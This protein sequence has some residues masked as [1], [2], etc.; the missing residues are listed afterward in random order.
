LK[1]EIATYIQSEEEVGPVLTENPVSTIVQDETVQFADAGVVESKGSG[2]LFEPT[3]SEHTDEVATLGKYLERPVL[4]DQF[5]WNE[6]DT[7]S[8]TPRSIKPWF[9]YF[10]NA[11]IKK[12]LDNFSRVHCNLKLTFR[13]NASPFY[14][15]AMRVVYDP[16]DSGK[17]DPMNVEDIVPMSQ[18]HGVM[19]EPQVTTIA[20]LE[21]PFLWPHSWLN[22]AVA[23]N[24]NRMGKIMFEPFSQLQSA[25]GVT[26]T[27]ITISTYAEA[28]D[29]EISGPTVKTLL[30]SGVVSGPA[31]AIANFARNFSQANVI[32]PY[33]RAVDIGATA[34]SRIAKIFGFSNAPITTNVNP[35]QN[36]VF[37]AFANTETRV[38]IDKLA[39]DPANEVTI[40]NRVTGDTGEDPMIIQKL[41][42]KPS[43]IKSVA[44]PSSTAANTI[45]QHGTVSPCICRT[46]AGT[47]QTLTYYTPSGWVSQCFR[48]WRGGMRYTFRVVRSKYHKGRLIVCWD[49]NGSIT[50]LGVETAIFS[51]IFDL[52][53]EDQEFTVDIPYKACTPWLTTLNTTGVA[54]T[55]MLLDYK[56]FNGHFVLGVLNPLTGP[57]GTTSV[58]ILI[59]AQALDDM[60]FAAP[61]VLPETVTPSAVQSSEFDGSV[62]KIANSVGVLD[63]SN[64]RY[65]ERIP[66]ITVGERI[67]SLRTLLH[68]TTRSFTQH[69]GINSGTAQVL[70]GGKYHTVNCFDR[71]P[72][73]YG[74]QDQYSYNWATSAVATGSK[75]CNFCFN[76]PINWVLTAF[77]GY[78][79]S[80]VVH[81]NVSGTPAVESVWNMSLTRIDHNFSDISVSNTVRNTTWQNINLTNGAGAISSTT[82][83]KNSGGIYYWPSGAG[84]MTVTNGKTQMAMSAVIPQ[85]CATRFMPAAYY[86]RNYDY[87]GYAYDGCRLDTDFAFPE[88]AADIQLWPHVDMYWAAGVDFNPVF[89]TGVPRMYDYAVPTQVNTPV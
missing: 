67:G 10:N 42:T 76:H 61:V 48:F 12:K 13:F 82:L 80:V 46:A 25:N 39:I 73:V 69:L 70:A 11:Y 74:F 47:G 64:V 8:L 9:L 60:E 36:K 18:T 83:T 24:F 23:D 16:L 29:I 53:S 62:E 72:P 45:L 38:P 43:I 63:E 17:F 85:Y 27:G 54:T 6:S 79:G 50:A 81:A 5:T 89:F 68:R 57:T 87:L 86:Q 44:W 59:S 37:H 3:Y 58:N 28:Y 51:K 22:T 75:P 7:F 77:A 66:D 4:I 84:G 65:S 41:V 33:A 2:T 35:V 88:T 71:L 19:L 49:P 34:V 21:L 14:Y 20:T 55:A 52:E 31:T 26:G 1:R 32:G 15:G 40:D 30:Q 78:R 56:A